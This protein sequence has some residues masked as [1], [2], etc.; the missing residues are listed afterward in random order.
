VTATPV[1][2]PVIAVVDYGIGNLHS[3]QKALARLG[4]DARLTDDPA[5]IADAA[6]V[7]L[8]GV[9]SFGACMDALRRRHLEDPV[10]DAAGSGRPFLGI[11]VGMQMLFSA[12]EESP[13]VTGLG[14]I[15][16]VIRWI[17]GD[18]K[19]PQMQWNV[20]DV[21]VAADALFAGLGQQPWFYFVHSLHGVPDDD[22][23][24]T[25]TCEYGSTLNAA[26]RVGLVA[27]VQF[28]PEK[29]AGAGL[30]LLGNFVAEVARRMG[31]VVAS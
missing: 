15:P 10:L 30:A 28:H 27:A 16:G 2:P 11:C 24:V 18:V 13:G 9:G 6:A 31:A 29:S 7:V 14:L 4:A 22:G 19:K 1:T 25:A 21:Q 5:V 26:F 3:A 20:V 8:P 12:S 17:P 23:A